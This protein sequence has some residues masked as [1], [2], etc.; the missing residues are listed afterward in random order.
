MSFILPMLIDD[1][2]SPP[3]PCILEAGSHRLPIPPDVE[4][5]CVLERVGTEPSL[6]PPSSGSRFGCEGVLFL[7]HLNRS[8]EIDAAYLAKVLSDGIGLHEHGGW[9]AHA[10]G[11]PSFTDEEVSFLESKGF[12]VDRHHGVV[13]YF[14]G[15]RASP[16]VVAA[17]LRA[18]RLREAARQP[19]VLQKAI[20]AALCKVG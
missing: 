15:R 12:H 4:I 5:G 13:F 3:A 16:P 17:T 11:D 1:T 14:N 18:W 8:D 20:S 2:P 7:A 19:E 10:H 9:A 6:V